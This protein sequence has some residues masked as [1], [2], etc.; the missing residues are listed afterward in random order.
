MAPDAMLGALRRVPHPRVLPLAASAGDL[1]FRFANCTFIE[2]SRLILEYMERHGVPNAESHRSRSAVSKRRLAN[3]TSELLPT[4]PTVISVSIVPFFPR[5][6]VLTQT[7]AVLH[8][9][10]K[11]KS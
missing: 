5:A 10:Q 2:I 1:R 8:R 7:T 11:I 9:L 6:A 3:R 4:I